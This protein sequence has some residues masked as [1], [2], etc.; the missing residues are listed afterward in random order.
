M[1]AAADPAQGSGERSAAYGSARPPG[2][3]CCSPRC[4][5]RAWP[6]IDATVVNIALPAIGATS[7]RT[8]AGLQWT[9][10]GYAL[11]LASL[12]L[13]G[14][15]LGDRYGRRRVFVIGVVWFALR[16]CSA[17]SRRTSRR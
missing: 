14:G 4:S 1:A 17:G 15:S 10:N 12:I 13:L 6:C 8:S 11:T 5:A 2:A 3:G 16:R 9:V 7:T